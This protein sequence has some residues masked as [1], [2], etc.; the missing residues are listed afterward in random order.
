MLPDVD[1]RLLGKQVAEDGARIHRRVDLLAVGHHRVA[2]QGVVVLP[3]RQLAD[4]ANLAVDGAQARAVAL[5]P[6]HAL[7]IGGRDLA[8]PL[9]QGA[10][11]IEEKLGVVQGSAVTLVD[12]DGHDDSRLPGSFADG[13]GGRD[14]TVT[15]WS[16]SFRCS[17]PAMFCRGVWTNEKYG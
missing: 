6:D 16:S 14:G 9:D 11:G 12:A 5:A 3:A 1:L 10:V 17:G 4:A 7:V 13:V 8:A 2:R 15:A